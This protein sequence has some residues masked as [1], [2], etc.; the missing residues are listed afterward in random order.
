MRKKFFTERVQALE[1]GVQE[2]GA[3]TIPGSV[4]KMNRCGATLC[5]LVSM[6]AFSKRLDFIIFKIFS[7][8]NDSVIIFFPLYMT[9]KIHNKLENAPC[10]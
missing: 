10:R 8:L 6:V 2:S 4:Q 7:N 3:V 1:W 5:G 9:N